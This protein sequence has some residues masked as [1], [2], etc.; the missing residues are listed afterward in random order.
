MPANVEN[1]VTRVATTSAAEP[2]RT[3]NFFDNTGKNSFFKS[4]SS[5]NSSKEQE[6]E[7]KRLLEEKRNGLR[8]ACLRKLINTF[9]KEADCNVDGVVSYSERQE[10]G[11]EARCG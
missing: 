10:V 5:L 9:K 11:I 1:T 6:D 4:G 3:S 8:R 2:P 7:Q